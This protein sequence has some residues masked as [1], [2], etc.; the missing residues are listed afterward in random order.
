[1]RKACLIALYALTLAYVCGCEVTVSSRAYYPTKDEHGWRDPSVSQSRVNN[2][3][4]TYQGEV[5]KEHSS[6]EGR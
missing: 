1:M 5:Y 3:T 4:S 6:T 2:V